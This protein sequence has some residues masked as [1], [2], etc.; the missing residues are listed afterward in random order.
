MVTPSYDNFRAVVEQ[1]GAEVVKFKHLGTTPFPVAEFADALRQHT[2]RL[3]YVVNP[4]N[5]IGYTL[6]PD[7]I[8]ELLDCCSGLSTIL[9]VD[10]AYFEFCGITAA[11]LVPQSSHLVVTRSFSKAFGLA[12]LRLGY[13]LAPRQIMRVLSRANNPKSVTSFA[14]VGA[15]AALRDVGHVHRY[16]DE[17]R[18]SRAEYERL[19]KRHGI[20]YFSSDS[21]FILFQYDDAKAL[22]RY[23]ERHNI[24]VRDRTSQFDGVGH[25]RISIGGKESTQVAIRALDEFFSDRKASRSELDSPREE[26]FAGASPA[27]LD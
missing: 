19:F 5:P 14:K 13:L 26:T 2:P 17:V 20:K 7:K 18:Q 1:R 23:L 6:G 10:E 15:L 22:I 8:K 25:V 9:I 27:R 3:A 16:V 4:N 21:N 24:F 11:D 12:G